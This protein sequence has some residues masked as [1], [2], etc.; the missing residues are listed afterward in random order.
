MTLGCVGAF[1]SGPVGAMP[2]GSGS[3]LA[4][5]GAR[6]HALNSVDVT[7]LVP[8]RAGNPG[9]VRDATNP[10]N[11]TLTPVD[12]PTSVNRLVQF[13]ERIDEL[14][15]RVYF[16]GPL[17]SF[18]TYE[19]TASS[20][21]TD[22]AGAP[23]GGCDS[24]IFATFGAPRAE[25][26]TAQEA[27]IDLANPFVPSDAPSPDSPLGTFQVADT[28]DFANDRD[29]QNLRKRVLRRATTREG[30][31]FHMP[32]YGFAPKLKGLARTGLLRTIQN[33]A[34]A[35]IRLEPDVKDVQVTVSFVAN[36]IVRMVIRVQDRY[37]WHSEPIIATLQLPS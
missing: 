26:A 1:G 14:T 15:M 18:V 28:G 33:N 34:N 4:V 37:G 20:S 16:D 36:N 12:P 5:V 6:Q 7:F 30:G 32:T 10:A 24:A 17:A 35:Q 19:I 21:I 23:L 31:F 13:V 9:D 25:V 8:P 29:R 27:T 11:W 2:F 3:L 22:P